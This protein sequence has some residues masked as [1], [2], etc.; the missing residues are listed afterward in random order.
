MIS[1]IGEKGCAECERVNLRTIACG[2]SMDGERCGAAFS[3]LVLARLRPYS[4]WSF[5]FDLC[6]LVSKDTFFSESGFN[7]RGP[8]SLLPQ[9]E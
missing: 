8:N 7:L 2:V 1:R 5:E 9:Y 4:C 6:W 3:A